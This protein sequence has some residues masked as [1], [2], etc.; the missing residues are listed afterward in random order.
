MPKEFIW[1]PVRGKTPCRDTAFCP[2]HPSS[3]FWGIH[4]CRRSVV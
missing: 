3:I 2:W 1:G 4:F